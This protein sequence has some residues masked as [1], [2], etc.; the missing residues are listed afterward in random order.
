MRCKQSRMGIE[1]VLFQ[2]CRTKTVILQLFKLGYCSGDR[3]PYPYSAGHVD[4]RTYS[5]HG[6]TFKWPWLFEET[7]LEASFLLVGWRPGGPVI[8]CCVLRL[9]LNLQGFDETELRSLLP[10]PTTNDSIHNLESVDCVTLTCKLTQPFV[11]PWFVPLTWY[12]LV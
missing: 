7:N 2:Y 1:V 12:A 5:L 4:G 8:C 11:C 6:H 10:P 9:V 3:M